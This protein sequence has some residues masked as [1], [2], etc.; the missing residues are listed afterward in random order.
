MPEAVV[1]EPDTMAAHRGSRV[2]WSET[3]T[4]GSFGVW[5][6]RPGSIVVVAGD[7]DVVVASMV[8]VD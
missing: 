2:L 3:S 4:G 5:G 8:V 7:R 1:A 6:R